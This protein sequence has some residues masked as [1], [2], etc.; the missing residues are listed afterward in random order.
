MKSTVQATKPIPERLNRLEEEVARLKLA[1][2]AAQR[3]VPEDDSALVA[4]IVH[5]IRQARARLVQ[6][7]YGPEQAPLTRLR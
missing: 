7:L 4:A 6:E 1:Y 5:D 2:L 3:G